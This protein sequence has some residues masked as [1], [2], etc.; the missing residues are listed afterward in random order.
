MMTEDF[1]L[2]ILCQN[3]CKM[4]TTIAMINFRQAD[5]KTV[6]LLKIIGKSVIVQ[7]SC[8]KYMLQ[9]YF[10]INRTEASSLRRAIEL[11]DKRRVK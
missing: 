1:F 7:F 2:L 8:Q 3:N 6:Q 9:C 4:S 10:V 11:E 5:D